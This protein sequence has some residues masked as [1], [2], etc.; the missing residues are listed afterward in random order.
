MK[1]ATSALLAV[2][3][4]VGSTQADDAADLKAMEGT[5]TIETAEMAGKALPDELK[6]MVL[7]IKGNTYQTLLGK[8]EDK[9]T[10]KLDSSKTPKSMTITGT[11]GPSKDKTF[12][13]I[14]EIKDDTMTV[15]YELS[16]TEAPKEFK[17]KEGSVTLL[18]KYK[19]KK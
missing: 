11:E 10:L 3:I 13:C 12:P 5:W 2:L 19:R 16:G 17:T 8:Q 15:C 18:V 4:V 9:G 1:F 14:Y 7:T 6:T